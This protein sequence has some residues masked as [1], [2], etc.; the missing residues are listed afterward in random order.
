MLK[1]ISY[2][3]WFSK[4]IFEER[5]N[6]L[7]KIFNHY[8]PDVIC[9][10]EVTP[11]TYNILNLNLKEKY[12]F[13]PDELFQSYDS[14]IL[15][16]KSDEIIIEETSYRS[17][18]YDFTNMGRKLHFVNIN[19]E[20]KNFLIATSHFESVFTN[21]NLVTKYYQYRQSNNILVKLINKVDQCFFC[22]D[23]NL[24]INDKEY[25]N[26]IFSKWKDCWNLIN[27]NEEF[28]YDTKKNP[29][30]KK[31]NLIQERVD[32]IL[33]YNEQKINKMIIL[34]KNSLSEKIKEPSDHYGLYLEL[35]ID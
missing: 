18:V 27:N 20:N 24:T 23:S 25:F 4:F 10:Q 17:I 1:I 12:S 9:L 26:D 22:F 28:T 3:I 16:K 5:L 30:C 35:I 19:Y 33:A 13:F 6:S 31:Y 7:I 8:N 32:R 14:I 21:P 29:Y 2:N 11:I 15:I 34:N